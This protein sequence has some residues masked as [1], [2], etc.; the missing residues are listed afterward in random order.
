M[1]NSHKRGPR[2]W[3]AAPEKEKEIRGVF[4]FLKNSFPFCL[5]P[6]PSSKDNQGAKR[7]V[8]TEEL[9]APIWDRFLEVTFVTK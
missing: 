5:L 1:S 2:V 7:E 9:G 3:W 8:G 4:P 6:S